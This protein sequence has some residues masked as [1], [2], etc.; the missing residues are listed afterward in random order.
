MNI[1]FEN[2]G[3]RLFRV[4]VVILALGML[5]TACS[6]EKSQQTF[7]PK[8]TKASFGLA[9]ADQ[10]SGKPRMTLL[11]ADRIPGPPKVMERN[12]DCVL[13]CNGI[14]NPD[15]FVPSEQA[16]GQ[17]PRGTTS[18]RF[19]CRACPGSAKLCR[20][21]SGRERKECERWTIPVPCWLVAY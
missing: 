19:V 12:L 1:Q 6:T 10:T 5:T 21:L 3:R 9:F 4:F 2:T 18:A 15:G 7:D 17:C 11:P 16:G 8:K 14:P 13:V 20:G